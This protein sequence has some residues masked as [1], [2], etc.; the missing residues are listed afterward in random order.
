MRTDGKMSKQFVI[1]LAEDDPNDVFLIKRALKKGGINNPVQVVHD[2]RE[3]RDYL[4]GNGKYA[5]RQRHPLPELILLDI[6]MPRM[7]GLEVLEWLRKVDDLKRLPVMIMSS[8]DRQDDINRAYESGV[9][10]YLV[11]PN[12]FEDFVNVLKK[13]TDFWKDAVAHPEVIR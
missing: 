5:D 4:E 7:T 11:K 3:A 1:L 12:A 13:T 8:S 10:A 9:N 2:G 6:K